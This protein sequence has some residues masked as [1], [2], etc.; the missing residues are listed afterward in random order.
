MGFGVKDSLQQFSELILGDILLYLQD[1]RP[2]SSFLQQ[3]DGEVI[4]VDFQHTHTVL[5]QPIRQLFNHA[6][7]IDCV[8]WWVGADKKGYLV[9]QPLLLEK[10]RA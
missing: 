2:N 5:L 7:H 9:A 6:L 4:E 3:F 8:A 1:A 10:A